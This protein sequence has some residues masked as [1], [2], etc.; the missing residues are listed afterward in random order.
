MLWAHF[1]MISKVRVDKEK[2]RQRSPLRW[3]FLRINDI[4]DSFPESE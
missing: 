1:S 4:I 2:R 3:N